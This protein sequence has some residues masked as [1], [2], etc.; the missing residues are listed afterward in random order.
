MFNTIRIYFCYCCL[1]HYCYCRC[2]TL[3]LLL[4]CLNARSLAM[5]PVSVSHRCLAA[6]SV[7][8]PTNQSVHCYFILFQSVIIIYKFLLMFTLETCTN[9]R[10]LSLAPAH[11]WM[12]MPV[13]GCVV[14]IWTHVTDLDISIK[15]SVRTW[16]FR[17]FLVFNKF[18]AQMTISTTTT[19]TRTTTLTTGQR[20][21]SNVN[22]DDDDDG[23]DEKN[24]WWQNSN[25]N[26][27]TD[28]TYP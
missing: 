27:D 14:D 21:Q 17:V 10:M 18:S 25:E 16:Y 28:M 26:Y 5:A 12:W 8:P 22:E 4:V 24:E 6:E 23:D 20:H 9:F 2:L 11:V 15:I 3:L 1:V 13:N 7:S 19:T